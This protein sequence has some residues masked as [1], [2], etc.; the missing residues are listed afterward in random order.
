MPQTCTVCRHAQRHEIEADLQAGLPNRDVARRHG[1]SKDAVSR[2]RAS[3]VSLH[4]TPA[5]ATVAKIMALVDN[6]QTAT[7][8]NTTLL[9]VRETRR[10]VEHLMMQLNHAIER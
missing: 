9:T 10:W 1:I 5:L 2:H 8:W 3:H 4:T 7:S 6:A